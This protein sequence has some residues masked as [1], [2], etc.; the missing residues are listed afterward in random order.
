MQMKKKS[1]SYVWYFKNSFTLPIDFY[2]KEK[3]TLMAK[4]IK[5]GAKKAAPKK[6]KK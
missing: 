5:K 2:K 3:L 1:F 6:D 4:T